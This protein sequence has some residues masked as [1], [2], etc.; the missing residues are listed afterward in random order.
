MVRLVALVHHAQAGT[1]GEVGRASPRSD[2]IWSD[3][4]MQALLAEAPRLPVGEVGVIAAA[5]VNGIIGR[6]GQLPW[7]LPQD[8]QWL[9]EHVRDSVFILG[10]RS[11]E[12]TGSAL[13]GVFATIVLTRSSWTYPDAQTATSLEDALCRAKELDGRR[14]RRVWI[15][16]GPEVYRQSFAV[17]THLFLTRI[18]AWHEGDTRFPIEHHSFFPICAWQRRL[19]DDMT[20]RVLRPAA[21]K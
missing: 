12:E 14:R 13:P 18:H 7:H 8:R 17:A 10:R 5:S 19:D 3:M 9:E 6:G 16:G 21:A 11:F 4:T 2:L 20:F 15:G 1:A